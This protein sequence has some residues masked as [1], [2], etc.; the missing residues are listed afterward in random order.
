[1]C[2]MRNHL[3]GSGSIRMVEVGDKPLTLRQALAKAEL[4]VSPAVMAA[5]RKRRLP[6][7]DVIAAAQIAGI[8]A[9]KRTAELIPLCHPLQLTHV[10]VDIHLEDS[11]VIVLTKVTARE[12]TGVEMEALTAAA[13]A[14]LTIYDMTK[15]LDH[16]MKV[17]NLCLLEKRGGRSGVW[18][19]AV[20]L[21]R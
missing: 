16:G 6:K 4:I 15:S 7:G 20:D 9:A 11:K 1:M 18:R 21:E 3:A 8:Q 12:S 19:R 17:S 2:R 5:I 14:A 13:T 10:D